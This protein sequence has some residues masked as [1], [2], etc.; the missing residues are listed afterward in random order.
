MREGIF[1]GASKHGGR[2]QGLG[3][4]ERRTTMRM[5]V[6]RRKRGRRWPRHEGRDARVPL[7][8]LLVERLLR[9]VCIFA[10]CA[11]APMSVA[12]STCLNSHRCSRV[13]HHDLLPLD[14]LLVLHLR[15]FVSPAPL[16]VSSTRVVYR[17]GCAEQ[18]WRAALHACRTLRTC[19]RGR[20]ERDLLQIAMRQ[21]R[22]R[23]IARCRS[24]CDGGSRQCEGRSRS[25]TRDRR[26]QKQCR[27]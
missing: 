21:G 20:N 17:D 24:Q 23:E 6:G 1:S 22:P 25:P 15:L 12:L 7:L 19:I 13:L 4:R 2:W 9:R 18:R 5:R 14:G 26:W 11:E 10:A 16:P 3:V 8:L 27:G